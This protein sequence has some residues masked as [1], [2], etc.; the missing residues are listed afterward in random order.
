MAAPTS[1]NYNWH[2]R[3]DNGGG[4]NY[5][6]VYQ[7][8]TNSTGAG[9]GDMSAYVPAD[10]PSATAVGREYAALLGI[11]SIAQIAYTRSGSDLSLNPPLTP[12]FDRSTIPY[13]NLYFSDTWHLKPSFTVTYGM[14]W[15]LEMP[16]V[17][18]DGKQV[19]LVDQSNQ[20]IDTQS[21]L[22]QRKTAALQGNVFNPDVGF[23][24]VG[25]VGNHRKYPYDPFYGGFSPRIAAAW[26]PHFDAD[27]FT[28]KMFGHD[29]T[30]IRGGYSRVY[31]R[32]NGVDLVL[33]PLLGT[34]LIQPVQCVQPTISGACGGAGSTPSTAF[35]IGTDGFTAPIP[36]AD[37]TLPQPDYP[38]INAVGAGAG[39]VLDPKFRPNH[40]DTFDFTIQRQLSHR[41]SIEFGYIGRIMHDEY[42]PININAVPYMMTLGGQ[43]FAQGYAAIQ[44]ASGFGANIPCSVT[45]G[46]GQSCHDAGGHFA[47][48]GL[49]AQP[50]FETAMNPGYCT[51]Y[52]N[53]TAAVVDKEVDNLGS[54]SVWSLYSDLDNGGFN[55]GRSMM[56]T[57]LPGQFGAS[58]QLSSGIGVNASI[59]HGTYNAFFATIKT[60]DWHGLTM[61]SNFTWSKALGTGATVQATSEYTPADAFSLD[62]TYGVQSWDRTFVY[63]FFFVY[64]PQFY[65]GQKGLA[66]HVLGGWTLAPVLSAGSGLP[67]QVNTT[68]QG[69]SFGEGDSSNFFNGTGFGP[70]E[71]AVLMGSFNGGNSRHNNIPGSN[72][73]GTNGFGANLFANPEAV[74]NQFRD[75]IVGLDTGRVGGAG[76]LRGLPFWNVDLSIAKAVNITERFSAEFS[77]VFTNVFNHVQLGDPFLEVGDP[78]DWGV[79]PGQ[80]NQPRQMEFGLRVRF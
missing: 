31:G 39:E 6:S 35:R 13:Y 10:A 65:K 28:G 48:P 58:G 67:I 32:L 57:P 24:L 19:L 37:P 76:T 2:Q 79:L 7:L 80:A 44:T 36:A 40:S 29:G 1:D 45:P 47:I 61:Q 9:I 55:F 50:F 78:A 77:T 18:K 26:N 12:A 27:S 30:V 23:A 43:S 11:V 25:N 64:Q 33:V 60:A 20:P 21:Y 15:T 53:C 42:Q 3:T 8:G 62:R 5:Q 38:G 68:T 34:G 59:G 56:N 17:E 14:G 41:T 46:T 54:H 52:A 70:G 63:N 22:N 72:G 51:G 75:P 69:Q 66:G 74:Y 4:I 49:A 71:N 16:P 73:I